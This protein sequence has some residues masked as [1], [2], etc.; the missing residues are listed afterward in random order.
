MELVCLL[1]SAL[2][3]PLYYL[4][5]E[6][7]YCVNVKTQSETGHGHMD[8][9]ALLRAMN[10]LV[11]VQTEVSPIPAQRSA[12]AISSLF[13]EVASARDGVMGYLPSLHN[14]YSSMRTVSFIAFPH[15]LYMPDWFKDGSCMEEDNR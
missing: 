5:F 12:R 4:Y 9:I 13:E 15:V 8:V 7:Q 1:C 11:L 2:G 10:L 6:F 3:H 14:V